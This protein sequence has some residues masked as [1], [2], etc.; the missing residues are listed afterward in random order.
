MNTNKNMIHETIMLSEK[1]N[2]VKR[3]IYFM[4]IQSD[5]W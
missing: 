4:K 3:N 1:K 5:L 2:C